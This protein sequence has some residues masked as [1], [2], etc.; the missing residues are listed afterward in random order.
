MMQHEYSS[1]VSIG[2]PAFN[3][4]RTLSDA[5]HSILLQTFTDWELLIVDDGSTDET[6][7]IAR[8]F[9][10]PRIRV[11][12][13]SDN[14]GLPTRLNECVGLARGQYFARMDA[15]DVS[16]SKRLELQL[17]Y[18]RAH[19]EIDLVGG[20]ISIFLGAGHLQG[21][22]PAKLSHASIC[23]PVTSRMSLAH[24][25]WCGRR[26]WFL[27]NPYDV[28][29]TFA[30]DRELLLRSHRYSTFAAIPEVLVGV[31]E[32]KISLAKQFRGR[33]Q[34][35]AALVEDG[36]HNSD[37]SSVAAAACELAKFGLDLSA[38]L[39]GLRYRVLRHRARAVDA[40][41]ASEWMDTWSQ[42]HA[43]AAPDG[44]T[45]A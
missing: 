37:L 35:I 43:L 30:Q 22:R 7:S 36:F 13:R 15:D 17:A 2:M 34:L 19:P 21:W 27:A 45:T 1:L 25:T 38:I 44:L 3:C 41:L 33:K 10:D 11:F 24:V 28:R 16:Y 6:V 9:S 32:E 4:A 12:T 23:G 18:L 40:N 42:V 8:S 5:I 14:Q 31:R 20:S 29:R 39:T 26:D